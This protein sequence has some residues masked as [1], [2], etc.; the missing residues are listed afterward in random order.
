MAVSIADL[1]STFKSFSAVTSVTTSAFT[2]TSNANRGGIIAVAFDNNTGTAETAS[3]GGVS[4]VKVT[5]TDTGATI[6]YRL[7][8]FSVIAPPS[9][10]QTATCSWSS[11]ALD[12]FI[13][14]CA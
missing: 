12:G 2:I 7:M 10:S 8:M 4:G 14:V 1:T 6:G 3:L 11:S 5:G 13:G 9:G